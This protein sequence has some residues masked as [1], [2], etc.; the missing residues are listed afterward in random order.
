MTVFNLHT[1]ARLMNPES[2]RYAANL[3]RQWRTPSCKGAADLIAVE[4][5]FGC[6]ETQNVYGIAYCGKMRIGFGADS[7]VSTATH[8]NCGP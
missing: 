1:G 5:L 2:D 6:D 4:M 3:K 8:N 7:R